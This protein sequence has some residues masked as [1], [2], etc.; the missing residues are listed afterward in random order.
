MPFE[1]VKG[2]GA[3]G[4]ADGLEAER[5]DL[6]K[7]REEWRAVHVKGKTFEAFER[8]FTYSEGLQEAERNLRV[9]VKLYWGFCIISVEKVCDPFKKRIEIKHKE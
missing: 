9:Y 4:D 5:K 6:N 8:G 1:G 2:G 7:R 3:H